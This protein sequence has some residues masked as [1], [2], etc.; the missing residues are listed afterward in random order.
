[1][2][3]LE[4]R[5]KSETRDSVDFFSGTSIGGIVALALAAGVPATK[6]ADAF[7]EYGPKL[8]ARR[9]KPNA[10]MNAWRL[11]R[12]VFSAPYSNGILE[13]LVSD[14]VGKDKRLGELDRYVLIPAFNLRTGQIQWFRNYNPDKPDE[15][16]YEFAN[17]KVTDIALA[18]SAAPTYFR[19]H[20]FK[21]T[22]TDDA[23]TTTRDM[24]D[25][26]DGG[27]FANCPDLRAHHEAVCVLRCK[28]STVNILGIG[29][30]TESIAK[31]TYHVKRWGLYY[32]LTD[33]RLTDVLMA[34]Q[35][36]NVIS[37]L[38]ERMSDRYVRIDAEPSQEQSE[39]MGLDIAGDAT[40]EI[41]NDLA[42][43]TIRDIW[44]SGGKNANLLE[45]LRQFFDHDAQAWSD[46]DR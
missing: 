33:H 45:P 44:D 12:N 25:Y 37:I 8:F 16:N 29:T 3:D 27:V 17:A 30:T 20:D 13:T 28:E 1:L 15:P 2:V 6:I 22:F 11:A 14:L 41:T 38:R 24:G 34:A 42:L 43:T 36:Q 10:V 9:R 7:K 23:G 5:A 40:V 32:W 35:Q 19:P 4:D 46:P 21:I 39:F 26:V 31:A 18:T